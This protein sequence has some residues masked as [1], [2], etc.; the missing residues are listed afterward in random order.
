MESEFA[1]LGFTHIIDVANRKSITENFRKD[2]RTGIYVLQ[3][4][5]DEY[6]VGI[7]TDIVKRFVQLYH[8]FLDIRQLA[9]KPLPVTALQDEEKDAIYTLEKLGKRFRDV[10]RDPHPITVSLLDKVISHEEQ[11]QWLNYEMPVNYSPAERKEVPGLREKYSE[12]FADLQKSKWFPQMA[13]L[14]QSYI[15]Q[16][17]PFPAQT[18]GD[19][20]ACICRPQ[21]EIYTTLNIN[22]QE[23][24]TIRKATAGQ[25]ITDKM[26]FIPIE[27]GFHLAKIRLFK[28]YSVPE[29]ERM[30]PTIE[31]EENYWLPGGPDQQ[32]L[33]M[34]FRDAVPFLDDADCLDAIKEFNLR[35]MHKGTTPS[36]TY[37]C[38]DLADVAFE[39]EKEKRL[40]V[41]VK[42]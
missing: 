39:V 2:N 7:T 35:L 3:F 22:W 31:L 32:L 9:F 29:L 41:D 10:N 11:Q 27:V 18:E 23:V 6:Y 13:E 30:F 17:I 37:H 24:F 38:Y 36:K 40:A 25:E 33:W 8:R 20:W 19:F 4:N 12:R 1:N 26:T 34:N 15:R 5:N 14:L 28:N 21:E 16:A 42:R